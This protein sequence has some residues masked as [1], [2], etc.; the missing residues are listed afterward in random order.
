MWFY[1]IVADRTANSVDPD[2]TDR[3]LH[4]LSRS[5]CR[6]IKDHYIITVKVAAEA[7]PGSPEACKDGSKESRD[8]IYLA[9]MKKLQ[10]GK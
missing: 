4:C 3:S 6:N 5:V 8:Q 10:F 2:Q 9:E 7:A 1:L